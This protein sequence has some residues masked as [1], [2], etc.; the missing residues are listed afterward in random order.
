[1]T[2]DSPLPDNVGVPIDDRPIAS[3]VSRT[4]GKWLCSH[5]STCTRMG[6]AVAFLLSTC[7]GAYW[8][9]SHKAEGKAGAE[10][11]VIGGLT[12]APAELDVGQA[13]E[14]APLVWTVPI[15]N[16]TR[17]PIAIQRFTVSCQCL[18]VEPPAL[19][20]PAGRTAPV[21][22]TLD[23]TRRSEAQI[24]LVERPFA[25]DIAPI[26]KD[27]AVPGGLAWTIHGQVRS[28]VTLDALAVDFGE[29]AIHGQ[30]ADSRRV[31]AVLHVPARILEATVDPTVATVKIVGKPGHPARYQVFLR[32]NP[33]LPPGAFTGQV[34]LHVITD[35]G[36]RLPGPTLPL[37]GLMQPEV[38]LLPARLL[39]GPTRVGETATAIVVVQAP[40]SMKLALEQVESASPDVD[41]RPAPTD[42]GLTGHA[43]RV[44][45]RVTKS[46]DSSTRVRFVFRGPNGVRFRPSM[47]VCC[48]GEGGEQGSTGHAAGG[49]K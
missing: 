49:T 21:K 41:V 45:Q 24:G 3:A 22:L 17:L 39:L 30:P 33:N 35:T 48:F 7:L 2:S 6:L 44:S 46:G 38:R 15:R 14:D 19:V 28:R 40:S 31:E 13:W 32:P 8:L 37:T 16:T 20:V 1:M 23:L 10:A 43:F 29:A 42:E 27:R 18:K 34:K 47:E 12:V 11:F 25:F 4:L 5:K 9:G 36:A 26:L